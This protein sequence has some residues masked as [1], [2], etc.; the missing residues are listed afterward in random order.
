MSRR[1]CA[2]RCAAS[3]ST[4]QLPGP[5]PALDVYDPKARWAERI[6]T[7]LTGLFSF[8]DVKRGAGRLLIVGSLG[9]GAVALERRERVLA[10]R[11][12]A[13]PSPGGAHEGGW[14]AISGLSWL[15]GAGDHASRARWLGD[16]FTVLAEAVDVQ[17][18]ALG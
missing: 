17:L 5:R 4:A 2:Q 1:F 6:R 10:Q 3:S 16:G 18:D 14:G 13:D 15:R 9:A 8:G 12:A 11:I 7:S